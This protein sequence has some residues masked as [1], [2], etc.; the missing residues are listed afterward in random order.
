MEPADNVLLKCGTKGTPL[1]M[2]SPLPMEFVKDGDRIIMRLEEYDTVR[3]I[4]MNP[5]AVPPAGAH[6]A[7]LLSRPLGGHH[8]RGRNGPHRCRLL[9]SRRHATE[10]PDQDGG[11][12]YPNPDH[13]RLDYTLTTTD[14]V[15]FERTVHADTVLPLETGEFRTPVRIAWTGSECSEP[16]QRA[17]VD[18]RDDDRGLVHNRDYTWS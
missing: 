15:N 5:K 6:A 10:R 18:R 8:A 7:R 4:H 2:I 12:V 17:P 1:I 16:V 13:S 11:A 14:P 3:T 9:R